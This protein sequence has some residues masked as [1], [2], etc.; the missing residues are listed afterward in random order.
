MKLALACD[1]KI[2]KTKSLQILWNLDPPLSSE[3]QLI[4]RELTQV[5]SLL[6]QFSQF[7]SKFGTNKWFSVTSTLSCLH[8]VSSP[9]SDS[10]FCSLHQHFLLGKASNKIDKKVGRIF[11]EGSLNTHSAPQFMP[12]CIFSSFSV[13][14]NS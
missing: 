7:L 4:L 2:L 6:S 8:H 11:H 14:K 1:V 5:P 12:K 3:D 9:Q 10:R 13:L